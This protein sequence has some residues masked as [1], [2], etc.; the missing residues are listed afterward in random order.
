MADFDPSLPGPNSGSPGWPPADGSFTLTALD[1]G[2]YDQ[3]GFHDASIMNYVSGR[4]GNNEFRDFSVFDLSGLPGPIT[5]A[6]L[7]LFN[8]GPPLSGYSSP[9]PFQTFTLFDVTTPISTL[10]ASQ[11]GRTDIFADLGTGSTGTP[12][13]AQIV[14]AAD[15]GNFV[16]INLNPAGLAALNAAEGKQIAF[17][18]AITDLDSRTVDEYIFGHSGG[19]GTVRLVVTAIPEPASLILMGTGLVAPLVYGWR[20]RRITLI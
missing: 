18:G 20:R 14:S 12:F 16:T 10:E 15:D 2:W 3:T 17:G 11:S 8:P 5:S 19:P 4:L 13:G 1:T 9:N 6:Q 7:Q